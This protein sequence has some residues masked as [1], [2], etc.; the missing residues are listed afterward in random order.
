MGHDPSAKTIPLHNQFFQIV[1]IADGY[2]RSAGGEGR[3]VD[4]VLRVDSDF[5]R[6]PPYG[7]GTDPEDN[8]DRSGRGLCSK[9]RRE[10]MCQN[11][12]YIA[13]PQFSR[14]GR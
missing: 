11:D 8:G 14:K 1:T 4:V 7:V 5:R 12:E 9:C 2:C 6:E 13:A 3:T 10:V